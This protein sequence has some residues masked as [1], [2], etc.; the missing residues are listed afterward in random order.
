MLKFGARSRNKTKVRELSFSEYEYVG[1][2]PEL[3]T[4]GEL[5]ADRSDRYMPGDYWN[6]T[7]AP[8]FMTPK[9]LGNL[10]LQNTALFNES[11]VPAEYAAAEYN[12]S[13]V[14]TAGYIMYSG[15]AGKLDYIAGVRAENTV[16]KYTGFAF[17]V[18]D[19]QAI[20]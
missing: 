16:N 2:E 3:A 14:I 12:A 15:K 20:Y 13:E 19:E 18:D 10:D 1:D 11:D 17:D 8:Y 4:D 5:M 7:S 9:F 6:Y